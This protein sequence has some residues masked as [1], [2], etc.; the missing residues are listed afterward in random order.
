MT[1]R[2]FKMGVG[3]LKISKEKLKF[4]EDTQVTL[5]LKPYISSK[6]YN[7]RQK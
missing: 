4:D 2:T 6:P 7:F 3:H 5:N 1:I